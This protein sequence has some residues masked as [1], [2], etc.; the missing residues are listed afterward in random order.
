MATIDQKEREGIDTKTI[1]LSVLCSL[2][3]TPFTFQLTKSAAIST[4][5]VLLLSVGIIS[6]LFLA[7]VYLIRNFLIKQ[8]CPT[9]S[10]SILRDYK[11]LRNIFKVFHK[12]EN[13]YEPTPLNEKQPP[14]KKK[15]DPKYFKPKY[16]YHE[17]MSIWGTTYTV[18]TWGSVWI[19]GGTLLATERLAN[20]IKTKCTREQQQDLLSANRG[21]GRNGSFASYNSSFSSSDS[22]TS[23][24]SSKSSFR[25]ISSWT[26]RSY[27][28]ARKRFN[29]FIGVGVLQITQSASE[30]SEANQSR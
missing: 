26:K 1:L 5:S 25:K 19:I 15:I 30:A 22:L 27:S 21:T 3:L 11:P 4:Q 2:A 6:T 18:I 7:S 28:A 14:N 29:K 16:I 20:K 12:D 23:E 9:E 13:N 17:L 10:R 8:R 24:G